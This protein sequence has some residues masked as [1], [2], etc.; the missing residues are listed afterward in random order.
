M[1]ESG[2][3]FGRVLLSN[4]SQLLVLDA[5]R[6]VDTE[7]GKVD[8]L[9]NSALRTILS[10]SGAVTYRRGVRWNDEV[11]VEGLE[12]K[13][14]VALQEVFSLAHQHSRGAWYF[15][16]KVTVPVGLINFPAHF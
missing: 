11:A 1:T 8:V 10:G 6:R 5:E 4:P 14:K 15:T 2:L 7:F 16:Y 13:E 9:V 12:T 3:T